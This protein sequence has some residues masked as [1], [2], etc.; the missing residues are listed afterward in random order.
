MDT[1]EVDTVIIGAGVAGL[2]AAYRLA[3]SGQS[4][5]VIEARERVGGRLR[6]ETIDGAML[7][8]GGQWVSPDQDAL[9]DMIEQLNLTTYSRHRTGHNVFVSPRGERFEYTGDQLPTPADTAAEIER[10]IESMDRLTAE[11]DPFSPWQHPRAEEFDQITFSQW[12]EQQ[13]SDVEAR[14]TVAMFI[15]AAML[16]KPP[17]AFSL[18]QALLM[19]ASAGSFSHLVDPNFILDKR[20]K[21]GLAE[22]PKK[23]AEKIG[24][25]SIH[26]DEP[27]QSVDYNTAGVRV[28]TAHRTVAAADCIVAVPSPLISRISFRPP[29]PVENYQMYQ[30]MSLGLVMKIHAVYESPFWRNEGLSGTAFGP[31][32]LVHEAYDNTNDGD[33]RGTLVGFISDKNAQDM[34]I[35]PAHERRQ[36]ILES[37]AKYYGPL[38]TEPVVYFESEWANEEW[39]QGAYA[40]SFD[41]GGLSRF[42]QFMRKP[43]GPLHFACSDIAGLG[44]QHV[45]GAI[46]MGTLAADTILEEG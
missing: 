33:E 22:V 32:E 26:L 28:H 1:T 18:L 3:E 45:D 8:L 20:V 21:G 41:V 5:C 11:V 40:A 27:V 43:I 29:L 9:I 34:L 7:E 39:T 25:N 24:W 31:K 4:V 15:G 44:Y 37:L 23:L 12:L 17:S 42:G 13:S 2:T 16:T 14:E 46:R 36:L 19:A 38:A 30:H 10:L 35:L 6:T